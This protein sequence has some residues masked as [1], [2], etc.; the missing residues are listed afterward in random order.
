VHWDMRSTLGSV[1]EENGA[2]VM[3]DVGNILDWIN[4]AENIRYMGNGYHFCDGRNG[5]LYIGTRHCAIGLP[6]DVVD[7]ITGCFTGMLPGDDIARMLHWC[8]DNFIPL[9]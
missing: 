4:G 2:V 5:L 6:W 1:N 3:I 9:R 7:F 8:E